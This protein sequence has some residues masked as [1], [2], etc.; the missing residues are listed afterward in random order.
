MRNVRIT[1]APQLH[2]GK[3]MIPSLN[4]FRSDGFSARSRLKDLST[5]FD[6]A[7]V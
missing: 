2:I 6:D 3:F 7:A 1:G 4:G 5:L